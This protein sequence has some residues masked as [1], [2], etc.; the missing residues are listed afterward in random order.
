MTKPLKIRV[1]ACILKTYIMPQVQAMSLIR[2]IFVSEFEVRVNQYK[3]N[4][5]T[6]AKKYKIIEDNTKSVI[7]NSSEDTNQ[8]VQELRKNIFLN[9]KLSE[10]SSNIRYRFI[11]MNMKN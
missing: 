6:V 5:E 9:E 2:K 10:N 11:S 7:V 3:F 8:L 1:F 4:F